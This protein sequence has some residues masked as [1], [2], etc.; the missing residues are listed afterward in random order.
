M[1]QWPFRVH[2][3]LLFNRE[4]DC[5]AGKRRPGTRRRGLERD[6]GA[7]GRT[8]A[9]GQLGGGVPRGRRLR[10]AGDLRGDVG[11]APSTFRK[12]RTVYTELAGRAVTGNSR[13]TT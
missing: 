11:S 6:A 3:L 10:R 9:E 4:G 2:R 5:L 12:G 1:P 7:G 8:A 13:L